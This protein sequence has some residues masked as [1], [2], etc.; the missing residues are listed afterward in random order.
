MIS[1]E[2]AIAQSRVKIAKTRFRGL[3]L[4]IVA[5]LVESHGYLFVKIAKTRFRGLKQWLLLPMEEDQYREVK[6][7]KIRFRGLKHNTP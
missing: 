7:A 2:F 6:I 4:T 3:K 5:S 1:M